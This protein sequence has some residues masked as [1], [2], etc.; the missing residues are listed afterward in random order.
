MHPIDTRTVVSLL[1]EG[2]PETRA[3]I[4]QTL[5]EAWLDIQSQLGADPKLWTWGSLHRIAF[6]H[7]LLARASGE[8]AQQ[9]TLP[10]YPRGGSAYTANNTSFSAADFLVRSGGSWRM[11]LD[12]G[13]WDRAFMTNAP[14]QSGDPRSRFYGNLLEPWA[15]DE[16]VPLLYSREAVEK[17]AAF[18]ILLHPAEPQP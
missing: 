13:S 17:N 8:L 1:K 6:E 16:Q 2:A 9:M 3:I 10:D 12:V 7:P 18:R 5:A 11:V 4:E 15:R 14:G